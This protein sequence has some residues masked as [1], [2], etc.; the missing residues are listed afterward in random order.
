MHYNKLNDYLTITKLEEIQELEKI[1]NC[2][3][4]AELVIYLIEQEIENSHKV[5]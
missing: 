3:D 2:R 4:F 1:K 5:A